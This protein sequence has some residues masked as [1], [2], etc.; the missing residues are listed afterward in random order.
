MKLKGNSGILKLPLVWIL[1]DPFKHQSHIITH[2]K[3]LFFPMDSGADPVYEYQNYP[4]LKTWSLLLA[5]RI[6]WAF[7]D[8]CQ[9]L[10]T[11]TCVGKSGWQSSLC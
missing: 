10:F 5:A 9:T 4:E 6:L 7:M 11:A 1:M 8:F 2:L 3:L